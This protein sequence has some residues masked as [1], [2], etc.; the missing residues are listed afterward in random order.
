MNFYNLII[1]FTL[2][3][4]ICFYGVS[5]LRIDL[6]DVPE[7]ALAGAEVHMT[8]N[9]DLERQRLYQ[10]KWY[11]GNHEFYRYSPGELDIKK[12]FL[13]KNLNID[14]R[15]SDEKNILLHNLHVDMTG[16]Y[17]CEVSTEGTFETVKKTA[18]MNVI[19]LPRGGPH[20]QGVQQD[21]RIGDFINLNCTSLK[22]KPAANLTFFINNRNASEMKRGRNFELRQS[23]IVNEERDYKSESSILELNF[24]VKKHHVRNGASIEIR[25]EASIM[26][27]YHRK[28]K[29]AEIFVMDRKA[30]NLATHNYEYSSDGESKSAQYQ[31]FYYVIII[32]SLHLFLNTRVAPNL[33]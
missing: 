16:T 1:W 27:G 2:I 33:A 22:S 29:L 13:V 20:I 14:L 10:V 25:C 17:T 4:S 30:E 7:M 19:A 6:L 26:N 28:S 18:K 12:S 32:A 21:V 5:S 3:S 24:R 15:R 23:L 8:C 31:S 9:Y 11:K